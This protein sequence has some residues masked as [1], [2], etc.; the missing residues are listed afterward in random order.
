M[1]RAFF[2]PIVQYAPASAPN[3]LVTKQFIEDLVGD[4]EV[5]VSDVDGLQAALDAKAPTASPALTGTPTAP[6]ATAGTDTTQIATT[7]FVAD[8]IADKVDT[9]DSRLSDARTPTA[10]AS[11]HVGD[12][13][14]AIAAATITTAGLM[15]ATDKTNLD[16][17][18]L[19]SG[20]QTIAGT[21][22]FSTSPVVPEKTAAAADTGTAIATEAQVY[23]K[24][25]TADAVLLTGD[26]TVAGVKTFS[27]APVVPSKTAA[28][29]DIG[30][31]IATEA[32]V[33]LKADLASPTFTGTPAAP[34][35]A[36]GTNT[37]QAATTAFVT[38]ALTNKITYGTTNLTPG[39]S[40][41]AT[42]VLYVTYE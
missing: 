32:Q 22:T 30:T 38:T 37:T 4:G 28:A 3:H 39:S 25:N 31:A 41:L 40:P 27:S 1:S 12:G 34:T 9:T 17:A 15:S 19:R 16:N 8:A 36:A 6:T 7:E 2:T 23:L 5:G 20:D 33:Y 29:A 13:T 42:G 35:A 11:T 10:H 18:V 24:A 21:K 14:D 26:Q